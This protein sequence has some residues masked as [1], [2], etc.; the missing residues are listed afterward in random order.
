M[1]A[2]TYN[3]TKNRYH[4]LFHPLATARQAVLALRTRLKICIRLTYPVACLNGSVVRRARW[5]SVRT[6]VQAAPPR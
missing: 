6:H 1:A 4:R 3:R 2:R 5:R